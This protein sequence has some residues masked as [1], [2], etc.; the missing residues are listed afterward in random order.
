MPELRLAELLASLS[1]ATDLAARHPSDEAL[2]A[3]VLATRLAGEMGLSRED[4]SHVYYTTLLRFVGCTAPM[5]EYAASLGEFDD[6]MRPRGDMTDMAN[7]REA[8]ALLTSL[9]AALPAWRRP[10]VWARVVTKG[11]SVAQVGV[12]ADCEVAMRMATRFQLDDAVVQSL[13]QTFERWDGHGMP[14]GVAHESI[15]LPARF[16]AVAFAAAMFYD[17]GGR[18][19]VTD[20][21]HRW[22]GKVLDPGIVDGFLKR[23]DELLASI[24]GV[25][26]WQTAL[27]L[28]PE[29][30]RLIQERRLDEVARGFADFVDLK[31]LCLHGHSSG[32]AALAEGAGR[33]AGMSETETT[34]LR[35]A[36]LLHDIGRA[37][38]SSSVW[39]KAGPLTTTEWEHVR[40]HPYHTE[41]ILSRSAVLEPFAQVA[42]MH[43][44]RIDSSGYHRGAAASAQPRSARILAVADVY[45]ALTEERA[46]RHSLSPDAAAR[47]LDAQPGLDRDSVAAVLEA[48]GQRRKQVRSGWPAGLSDREVEILRLLARGQ[49]MRV[50]SE[51]LFISQSTVHTHAAHIYEKTGVSTRAGAALFAMENGLLQF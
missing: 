49:S 46:H 24:D 34:L 22:S 14:H 37:A 39:D 43:H 3:C 19:A 27:S 7:P 20:A 17:A 13:N 9:G 30:R 12:R 8:L 4:T 41:R 15:A 40:L 36:G 48:A 23:P 21:L 32:V 1:L 5:P 38:V 29:P 44:E 50:I 6:D 10:A 28:E 26:A 2:R 33:A 45:Q 18:D 35:R 11:R 42:G 16:A 31:S 25:D 47:V 51:A